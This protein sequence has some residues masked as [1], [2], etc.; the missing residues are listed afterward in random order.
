L[1][2]V[3]IVLNQADRGLEA[4]ELGAHASDEKSVWVSQVA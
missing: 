2:L 4:V 1:C 3:R